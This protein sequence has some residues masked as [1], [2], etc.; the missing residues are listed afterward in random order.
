MSSLL[1]YF[2]TPIHNCDNYYRKKKLYPLFCLLADLQHVHSD[3]DME[4]S[5]EPDTC[6]EAETDHFDVTP[7]EV[8][9]HNM[10]NDENRQNIYF[11]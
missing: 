9:T 3:Y 11:Y 7:S 5:L 4:I 10:S 8:T 2:S 6:I 1:I